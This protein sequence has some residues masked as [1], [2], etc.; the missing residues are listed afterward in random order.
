MVPHSIIP[1]ID[2]ILN[3]IERVSL[4][5]QSTDYEGYK[6]NFVSSMAVERVIEIVSEASRYL[7]AEL[8]DAY[9][10]IPWHDIRGIGIVFATNTSA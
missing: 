2:D 5:V 10:H 8:T 6:Q 7:P 3:A 4:I 1:R 9:P